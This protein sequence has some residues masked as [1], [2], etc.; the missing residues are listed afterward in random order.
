MD[1]SET[2][3]NCGKEVLLGHASPVNLA[4]HR[5]GKACHK[6]QRTQDKQTKL[7]MQTSLMKSYFK[8]PG[9]QCIHSTVVSPLSLVSAHPS[10][11]LPT[12]PPAS[13][14]TYMPTHQPAGL[15]ACPPTSPP[16]F[17]PTSASTSSPTH[18]A[19]T[20]QSKASAAVASTLQKLTLVAAQLPM[21]IPV[22]KVKD[23]V[24][25]LCGNPNIIIFCLEDDDPYEWLD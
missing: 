4:N 16:P 10:A 23:P 22:A 7:G 21:S 9:P 18:K 25:A 6:A 3:P 1:Y 8:E 11:G 14:L 20:S 24:A 5:A 19:D 2:C 13:P 15:P 12:C 17:P